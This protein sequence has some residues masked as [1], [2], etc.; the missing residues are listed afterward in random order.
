MTIEEVI[1]STVKMDNAKKVILNIMYTQ[2]VINDNFSEL[3]KPY[4]LSGE[5]Y[6][7][8]RILRGQKGK[9]ANMCVI[10]ER[11]LAKTSNT[12]RLVDKLLLKDLVTR[13]VCSDNRRKIEVLITQ[14]GLD[15]LKELDPKVDQH[16]HFF[17]KNISPEELEL[18]NY[19]LEKYRTNT[20]N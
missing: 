2:N 9:P 15:I 20:N 1:K 17:A 4:D 3:M 14:K 10:Q 19:L 12:T 11:M 13:N 7:V 6:N 8:L 18:L 16:E 5:Q